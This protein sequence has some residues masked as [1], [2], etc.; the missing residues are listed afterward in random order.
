MTLGSVRERLLGP[1]RAYRVYLR[2]G[3][4]PDSSRLSATPA[5]GSDIVIP[6]PD[7]GTVLFRITGDFELVAG[8][9]R[10]VFEYVGEA[11]PS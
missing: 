5:A 9:P 7:G 10:R 3:P 1:S 4:V 6:G 11:T 8:R 2:G